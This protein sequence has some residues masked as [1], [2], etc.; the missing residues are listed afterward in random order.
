MSRDCPS[1]GEPIPSTRK[2]VICHRKACA[3]WRDRN[4]DLMPDSKWKL[5]MENKFW[6]IEPIQRKQFERFFEL[7]RPRADPKERRCLKCGD[8]FKNKPGAEPEDY[9]VCWKCHYT[10]ATI[11]KLAEA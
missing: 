11:G 10:N 9:R 2:A 1:C 3:E 5:G 8:R 4:W 6:E 7:M